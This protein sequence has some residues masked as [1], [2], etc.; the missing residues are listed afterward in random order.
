MSATVAGTGAP[1]VVV[2]GGGLAGLASAIACADGGSD[3]TLFESRPRLG[4]ATWSFTRNGLHFDNGQHV[5]MRCCTA[6]RRFLDRIG[7]SANA[8]L[9]ERLAIPVLKPSPCGAAPTLSW[10]RRSGLPAPLQLG[11]SL[12]T[13]RHL[14]I[15]DRSRLGRAALALRRVR[16]TDPALDTETL[17]AFLSRHGQS[18]AAI[19]ALWDLIALPTV[20]V[21]A[22]Q[23]SLALAAK[24]FKTGLL[25]EAGAADL[26]WARVPLSE[27]H[28]GP[29]AAVLRRAGGRV[30][31]RAKVTEIRCSE[32][33][34][35][36]PPG[37]GASGVVVDGE[38]V[39]AD[40]VV[41][42][43]PH[44]AAAELMPAGAAFDP[45]EL[46]GLG[47]SPIVDVHLVY[48]RRVLDHEIAA[49]VGSPVQFVFDTTESSGLAPGDGQ[50]VAVSV[51]GADDE[52]GVRPAELIEKYVAALA[53][54]FPA[55]RAAK[56]VDA[57]VTK[58]QAATFRGVPGTARLR[59]RPASG[60]GRLFLAGAW[61]DTG[62]PATMEGAVRSG[63]AA[64]AGALRAVGNERGG[65]RVA[66]TR[67]TRESEFSEE[68]VV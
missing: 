38:L 45:G 53:E 16:L 66:G 67:V 11:S 9:Q 34:G 52:I 63:V 55:A 36:S 12:L 35:D 22:G 3:V 65:A 25:E 56:V 27:L 29:A 17:G 49:A 31:T 64:A 4:G 48:D 54:L 30:V 42:A 8:P 14:S 18:Q 20:N 6:Y 51:S 60:V 39:E 32:F 28:G 33:S 68:V 19:A 1:R 43:V 26:G 40:A 37:R 23:A 15:A 7:S 2:V 59:P 50:C 62:W 58:E 13:Y 57:V 61:T 46:R 47:R 21:H 10:I 5:Y 41:L 44:E 24:V